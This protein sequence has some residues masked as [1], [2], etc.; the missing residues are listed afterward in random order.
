MSN[1]SSLKSLVGITDKL[2]RPVR[3]LRISV[4][5]RCN[6]RCTYC[7][8]AEIFGERY[9]FLPR[10]EILTFEEIERVAR[11]FAAVGV[12]KLRITGGEPLV[13]AN[14]S[15]LIERL[16]SIEEIEDIAL[17]TNGY[18]LPK[19]A[20]ELKE[21]GLKRL[22]ISLDSID[23]EIF[24]KMSG[25]PQGPANTLEGIKLATELGFSPIKINVVVQ[26]AVNDH[27]LVD[28][29]RYFKGT[30]AIVRFIEFMDVGTKNG[31]ELSEVVTSKEVIDM[32]GSE[33]PLEPVDPNYTGEVASRY[34]YKDGDGEIGVISS[35]SEPFCGSCTRA[36]L[37]TD[38]KLVTCLFASGG[39]DLKEALRSG[40]SDEEI[41][42]MIGGIWTNRSDRYSELRSKATDLYVGAEGD[43]VEMYY[44]GG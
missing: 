30:G 11:I 29:A 1:S 31:W 10:P 43:K 34:R 13:R 6:F 27:T 14:L 7:M 18:L 42:E 9:E 22:T 38:G 4:T 16:S 36:R 44:I 25:R 12:N 15:E 17:T 35:V 3:D 33:F 24:K 32:I 8:P 19:Y 21:A 28:T 37:S 23:E 5:D 41:A 2:N 40:Q 26:R 39:T 20:N